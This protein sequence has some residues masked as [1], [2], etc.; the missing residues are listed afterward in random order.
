[1][2]LSLSPVLA[3]TARAVHAVRRPM[4]EPPIPGMVWDDEYGW[5][6][7]RF[8]LEAWKD[9]ARHEGYTGQVG[10]GGPFTVQFGGGGDWEGIPHEAVPAMIAAW[11]YTLDH[12]EVIRRNIFD[13]LFQWYRRTRRDTLQ[14]YKE[15]RQQH[16]CGMKCR[17]FGCSGER[18][19]KMLSVYLNE[20]MP[21]VASPKQ[22]CGMVGLAGIF[23][24]EEV[25]DGIGHV[26]YEM[27]CDWDTEHGLGIVVHRDRVVAVGMADEA[28]GGFTRG[29]D[30][31]N[32][33]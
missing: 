15:Y 5:W 30:F 29:E 25:D 13:A 3:T 28:M 1:M 19:F 2:T 20:A 26:G 32:E 7:G 10:V 27:C 17:L 12:Q 4:S 8:E 22:L 9:V 33:K 6:E 11:E 14:S 31:W 24:L 21:P 18:H 16:V 23:L